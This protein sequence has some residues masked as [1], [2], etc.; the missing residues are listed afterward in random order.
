MEGIFVWFANCDNNENV[1][2]YKKMEVIFC[3]F[4]VEGEKVM[5]LVDLIISRKK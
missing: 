4:Y 2:Y 5:P 3:I 1:L